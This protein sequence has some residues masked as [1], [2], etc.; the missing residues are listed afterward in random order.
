MKSEWMT[1]LLLPSFSVLLQV[2][3]SMADIE[4][5]GVLCQNIW[6]DQPCKRVRKALFG[7]VHLTESNRRI[8]YILVA[9]TES[10]HT[11]GPQ[12]RVFEIVESP[13][14]PGATLKC[15]HLLF[16]SDLIQ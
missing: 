15:G 11:T 16:Y 3:S 6:P 4:D 7:G 14:H 1:L 10:G 2:K 12:T 5:C 13:T 9:Q 8:A